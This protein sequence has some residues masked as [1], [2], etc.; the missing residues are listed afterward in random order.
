MSFN[1]FILFNSNKNVADM[2]SYLKKMMNDI[3]IINRTHNSSKPLR[4][5]LFRDIFATVLYYEK[6]QSSKNDHI[7]ATS[8]LKNVMIKKLDEVYDTHKLD[9]IPMI[10]KEMECVKIRG[11]KAKEVEEVEDTKCVGTFEGPRRSHRKAKYAAKAKITSIIE[12]E[13]KYD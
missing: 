3:E 11:E 12:Y 10:K 6:Y 4:L 5:K 8:C 2:T 9:W 1:N 7:F 13:S